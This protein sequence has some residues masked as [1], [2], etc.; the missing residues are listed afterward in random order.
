M[1][2][3]V[4]TAY[5]GGPPA[6]HYEALTILIYVDVLDNDPNVLIRP[7]ACHVVPEVSWSLSSNRTSSTPNL[8]R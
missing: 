3:C 8:A 1:R 2:Q 6:W 5:F 4:I 7:A